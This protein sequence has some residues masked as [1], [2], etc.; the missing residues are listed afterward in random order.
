MIKRY[1]AIA[2]K[3]PIKKELLHNNLLINSINE[4]TSCKS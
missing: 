4:L 3:T 1:N 2:N